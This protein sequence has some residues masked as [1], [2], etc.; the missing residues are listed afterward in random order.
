MFPVIMMYDPESP[1]SIQKELNLAIIVEA[2][3]F[4]KLRFINEHYK[5]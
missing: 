3:L 1:R 5:K 2:I 4:R